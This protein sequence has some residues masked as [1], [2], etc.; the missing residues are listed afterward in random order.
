MLDL[1]CKYQNEWVAICKALG[2]PNYLVDDIIQDMYLKVHNASKNGSN[3]M[4]SETEPNKYYIYITLRN[5]YFDW[6]KSKSKH[7]VVSIDDDEV[8]LS[9][10]SDT[11]DSDKFNAMER[12]LEKIDE[13]V[14]SW[15]HDYDKNLFYV[16]Y[17]GNVSMR[18]LSKHTGISLTS[19]F[20]SCKR[21]KRHLKL[22]LGEDYED[23][24]NGDYNKIK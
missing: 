10:E 12:L 17:L 7:R 3:I 24:L 22:H 23:F 20:N 18:D 19:I 13:K 5:L 14:D 2:V 15:E 6:L 11:L 1:L 16:Y 8:I 9:L 21:Y 4:Y